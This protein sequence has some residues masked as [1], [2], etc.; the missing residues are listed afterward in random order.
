MAGEPVLDGRGLVRSES[1]QTRWTSRPAGTFLSIFFRNFRNS[2]WRW[3][4]CSSLITVPS[5][6]SNAANRLVTPWRA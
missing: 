1:S 6:I 2:W 4:R 5:A 3:R